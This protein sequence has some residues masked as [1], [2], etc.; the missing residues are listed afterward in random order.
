MLAV[1]PIHACVLLIFLINTD[2]RRDVLGTAKRYM[3]LCVMGPGGRK[4]LLCPTA[5]LQ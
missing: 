1:D 5:A 3:T 2:E 4:P